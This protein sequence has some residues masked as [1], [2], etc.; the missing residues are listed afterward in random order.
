MGVKT[1]VPRG[2]KTV[3]RRI[4]RPEGVKADGHLK[5]GF[6]YLKGGKVVKSGT[7]AKT[8]KKSPVKKRSSTKKK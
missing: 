4:V 6:K 1:R 7:K 3:C 5:K 8:V 2:L